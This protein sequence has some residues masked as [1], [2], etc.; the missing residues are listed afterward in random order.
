MITPEAIAEARR[1]LGRQLAA[2][3]K[4]AGYNSEHDLA[5]LTFFGR[6]TIANVEMGRQHAG[7]A[8]W[9][10]CD[11]VLGTD[12]VLTA[13]YDEIE[14]MVA[15]QRDEAVQA[16]QTN[17]PGVIGRGERDDRPDRGP[18]WTSG[19]DQAL[20]EAVALWG[21]EPA[22]GSG[23]AIDVAAA[24]EMAFRWLVAPRDSS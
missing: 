18:R 24:R 20:R 21:E 19:L 11:E 16:L 2:L 23:E 17:R 4:A 6:S 12:G 3:R 10:R 22:V 13:G 15:R 14:A 1:Q 8:F 7:R 9:R 5:P